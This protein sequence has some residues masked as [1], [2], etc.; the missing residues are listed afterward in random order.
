MSLRLFWIF[1]FPSFLLLVEIPLPAAEE[2]N[3]SAIFQEANTAYR[4]RDYEQAIA[5]YE[6]LLEKGWKQPTVYYNLGNAYF[7]K[8]RLGRAILNYERARRLQPRNSDVN[9][10]LNH[11]R[12]LL[13]YRTDDKRNWYVKGGERLLGA[14][15]P[16]E[17]GIVSL[18]LSF[19]FLGSLGY[20]LYFRPERLWSWLRKTLFVLTLGFF[21]L[22]ILKGIYGGGIQEAIVLKH[23]AAVRY[24]PSY[25]DQIAFRLGEGMKVRIKNKNEG[26]VR[27]VLP[28]QETGWMSFEEIG[29]I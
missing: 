15:T 6:S 2:K 16:E 27:V 17:V 4:N 14:F 9:A 5:L 11:T 28:N 26:W 21:S 10:N 22:W 1:I 19:I 8:E 23:E 7:K 25:K 3:L 29:V 18:F 12:G 13:E 20:S 24:G